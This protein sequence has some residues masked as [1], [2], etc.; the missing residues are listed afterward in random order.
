MTDAVYV[1]GGML[2]TKNNA[3]HSK[4]GEKERKDSLDQVLQHGKVV[5]QTSPDMLDT[6][7]QEVPPSRKLEA[8]RVAGENMT[9]TEKMASH[10]PWQISF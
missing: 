1:H 4:K 3:I 6:R 8:A 9:T 10:R 2:A 5:S 7:A